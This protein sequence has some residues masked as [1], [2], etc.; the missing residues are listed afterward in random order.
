MM[1]RIYMQFSEGVQFLDLCNFSN[2]TQP[3]YTPWVQRIKRTA[4]MTSSTVF[5]SDRFTLYTLVRSARTLP[6]GGL[7][8]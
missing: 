7:R 2:H 6:Q 5:Y 1:R 3:C 4:L 8:I